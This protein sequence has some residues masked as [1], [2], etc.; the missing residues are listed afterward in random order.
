MRAGLLFVLFALG[1]TRA[2]PKKEEDVS[3][4]TVCV[5]MCGLNQNACLGACRE[6]SDSCVKSCSDPYRDCVNACA[7][8]AEKRGG[9]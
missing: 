3:P 7:T 6:G 5:T 2:A 1:C 4:A 9:R 8:E